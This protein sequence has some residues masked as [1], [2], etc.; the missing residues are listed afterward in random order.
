MA[1]VIHRS[2]SRIA[3]ALLLSV[4]LLISGFATDHARAGEVARNRAEMLRLT[5]EARDHKGRDALEL[6]GALS[7]YAMR[8]SRA[9]AGEGELFHTEDLAAKLKGREW[10]VGG[11][12]VGVASSLSDLQAAFMASKPHRGNI[13]REDFEHTAIGV[14]KSDGSFW[15]TVIFYG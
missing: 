12:N 1:Q 10:S 9:M 8:H 14:V 3:A 13:L 2:R 5:N 7:K 11:E 4:S 15:V 6:D